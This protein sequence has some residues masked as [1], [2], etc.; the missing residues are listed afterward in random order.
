MMLFLGNLILNIVRT[1]TSALLQNLSR[2]SLLPLLKCETLCLQTSIIFKVI[3]GQ[4]YNLK[5]G[6]YA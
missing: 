3:Y 2:I 4:G 1:N 6:N 5:L